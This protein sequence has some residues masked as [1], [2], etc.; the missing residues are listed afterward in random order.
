[1]RTS[2]QNQDLIS[3]S[4]TIHRTSPHKLNLST[5][6]SFTTLESK[7]G[8][9]VL[10]QDPFEFER[11]KF[12]FMHNYLYTSKKLLHTKL[13]L[14]R[15]RSIRTS[16]PNM[17]LMSYPKTINQTSAYKLDLSTHT[18]F[19]R[20][21]SK[22]GPN[23]LPQDPLGSE[24]VD[25][26]KLFE[27]IKKTISHKF[28]LSTYTSIRTSTQNVVLVSY[29]HTINQTSPHKL[30]LSTHTSFTTLKSKCGPNV[31]PTH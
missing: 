29:P 15:H 1:M 30:N 19:T 13:N 26:T 22:S 27:H 5:H 14:C 8:T 6:T 11:V 16:S 7:S 17:V 12:Q 24:M 9:N 20:L 23:V 10:L 18:S 3:Y 28:N 25:H 31:R 2:S 21:K 4:H